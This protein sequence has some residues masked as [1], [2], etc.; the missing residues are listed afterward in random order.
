[1]DA[2]AIVP[3]KVLSDA[4]VPG[5][6]TSG[7]PMAEAP[8]ASLCSWT[9]FPD[10]PSSTVVVYTVPDR[11][12]SSFLRS[13]DTQETN[14]AGFGA[15]EG[16]EGLISLP[17]DR[18]CLLRIDVADRQG[19]WVSYANELGDLPGGNHEVMCQKA[20]AAAEGIIASLI[21]R[22]K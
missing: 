9:N 19:L 13:P 2:C 12:T 11:E 6:G 22:A 16:A 8:G 20:H 14:V 15:V 18:S 3:P 10:S 7:T 21:A 17:P 1:M 5:R 4:G